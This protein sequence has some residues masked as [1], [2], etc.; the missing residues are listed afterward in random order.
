MKEV[1]IA[2]LIFFIIFIAYVFFGLA[3]PVNLLIFTMYIIGVAYIFNRARESVDDQI[4]V[5]FDKNALGE[6]LTRQNLQ[7]LIAIDSQ[8]KDSYE[9]DK[10]HD[11]P[12]S[13]QNKSEVDTIYIDWDNS[14]LTGYDGR[15]RRVIR[16][17]PTMSRNSS[18]SQVESVIAPGKTLREQLT[19]EDVL[20]GDAAA[21]AGALKVGPLISL[22]K[23]K[24]GKP[25]EKK[26]YNGFMN[27]TLEL[28]FD[29]RLRLHLF[30]PIS[31]DER[32]LHVV[33]CPF[34]V[35]KLPW[36]VA[37]PWNQKK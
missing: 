2:I 36:T 32:R 35:N 21:T 4:K 24:K 13:I 15:S 5:T 18:Q 23:L 1:D 9:I 11:L 37:L 8:L 26:I 22:T 27:K 31:P 3:K 33:D 14:S 29:L 10:L 17:T 19:A 7:D 25:E 12:I 16:L 30:G 6:D 20:E 34:I 28:K